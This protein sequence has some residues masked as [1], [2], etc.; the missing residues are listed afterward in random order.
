MVFVIGQEAVWLQLAKLCKSVR[1]IEL[2]F[3]IGRG[4]GHLWLAMCT[5]VCDVPTMHFFVMC[6]EVGCH[7][8]ILGAEGPL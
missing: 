2:I 5:I 8:D 4:V 1:H 7:C 3:V 6:E